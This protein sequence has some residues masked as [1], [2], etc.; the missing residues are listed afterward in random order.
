[1]EGGLP[2]IP[3]RQVADLGNFLRHGYDKVNLDVL[4]SI[5]ENDLDVLEHAI[6][7]LL[8]RHQ[9]STKP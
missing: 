6:D 4:W 9:R 2:Q 3:W 5:Y 8:E 1:M 7:T